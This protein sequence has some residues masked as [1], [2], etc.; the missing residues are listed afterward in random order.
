MLRSFW[1]RMA[2]RRK[3]G[4]PVW[5]LT[6]LLIS[7][8]VLLPVA[9]VLVR[10][11]ATEGPAWAGL[12]D[13]VLSD[14]IANTTM[15]GLAGFTLALV[16]GISGAWLVSIYRF[17]FSGFLGRALYLPLAIPTYIVAYS[18]A[19]IFG[20]GGWFEQLQVWLS[21]TDNPWR[22]DVKNA[23]MLSLLYALVLFPYVFIPCKMVF[24]SRLASYYEAAIS[25]G[26]KPWQVFFK[27][28]LPLAR[29]AAM[30]GG[31]LVLME[32][33]NDY[34]AA[35]Y[36]GITT[37][38]TGIFGAWFAK[39][40][41]STAVRFAAMLVFGV[42]LLISLERQMRGHAA[43]HEKN[44]GRSVTPVHLSG[45]SGLWAFLWCALLFFFGFG[46]VA[47]QLIGRAWSAAERFPW[48]GFGTAALHSFALAGIG[49]LLIVVLSGLVTYTVRIHPGR[50]TQWIQRSAAVGYVLPGA[51]IAV[52]V[53]ALS[54]GLD[55]SLRAL[56]PNSLLFT[57]SLGILMLAYVSRFFAVG[58]K[59]LEPAFERIPR[60][61]DEAGRALGKS[62]GY[63]L[64]RLHL[65]LMP[66]H[67]AAVGILVFIDLLKELPLTL[68]LRPF[69]FHTLATRTFAFADNEMLHLASVPALF[70]VGC[71]MLPLLLSSALQVKK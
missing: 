20:Y 12:R 33:L 23:Y 50:F 48:S 27:I 47:A 54:T 13:N 61:R 39:G 15:V 52:G 22:P 17:P 62:P 7:A 43:F 66:R 3:A 68:I 53:L 58:L 51:V 44:T 41:L 2:V 30:G 36:F 59:Q 37:L 71:G 26:M 67:L 63:I 29:P 28:M 21:G 70:I 8:V 35:K 24:G 38:T 42:L 55:A 6:A 9:L 19:D 57:G 25:L 32:I 16:F 10:L 5:L 31:F 60:S 45:P 40:D 34:G 49:A 46:M 65:P 14:Y 18:Y 11:F 4:Y 69:N 64:T 56:N 1:Q